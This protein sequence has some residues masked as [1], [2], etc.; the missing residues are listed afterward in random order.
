MSIAVATDLQHVV[1]D[2]AAAAHPCV[3]GVGIDAH[4]NSLYHDVQTRAHAKLKEH[5][6][7]F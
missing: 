7:R 3:W 1:E 2:A 5:I 4:G 6:A